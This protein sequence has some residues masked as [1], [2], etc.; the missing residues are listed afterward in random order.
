MEKKWEKVET[1]PTWDF[2]GEPEFIGFF[3][4]AEAEVGPNKSNL[5]N[6]KKENGEVMA[7]WGN[8]ILDARFKNLE[9]GD[10]VK[11]IYKGKETSP[12]T[13]REYNNFDVFKAKKGEMP[14]KEQIPIVEETDE[15]DV[16]DIPF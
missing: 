13:G 8:T 14:T 15:V 11:I 5:Y 10:E 4:S 7:V 6:F 1:A 3:I 9:I 2:K 16:K 12:K